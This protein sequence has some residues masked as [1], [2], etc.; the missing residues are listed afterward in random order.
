MTPLLWF[1][2]A[3]LVL[4]AWAAMRTSRSP[5][6]RLLAQLRARAARERAVL[7][8]L[9]VYRTRPQ[10]AADAAQRRASL[11]RV[12]HDAD[13]A[14]DSYSTRTWLVIDQPP[15]GA[16]SYDDPTGR[17]GKPIDEYGRPWHGQTANPLAPILKAAQ[18]ALPFVPGVG[19]AASAALAASIAVARGRSIKDAALSAARNAVPGGAAGQLAFDV[20][21]AVA[22]GE[23]VDAAAATALL[24]RVPSADAAFELGANAVLS[25]DQ[26]TA[27]SQTKGVL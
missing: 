6:A 21:V 5:G 3:L 19:P 16:W 26:R 24:A 25:P 1:S 12:R 10:S 17:T 13:W 27:I 8:P 22:S 7:P 20:G 14:A 23:R 4:G 9:P 11:M 18:I 2:G 15:T